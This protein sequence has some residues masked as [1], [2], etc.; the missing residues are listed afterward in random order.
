VL[1]D[2]RSGAW[3]DSVFARGDLGA[4]LADAYAIQISEDFGDLP[5]Q[6]ALRYDGARLFADEAARNARRLAEQARFRTRF[7]TGAT[8]TLPASENVGYSFDPNEVVPFEDGGT[9]Y[10]TTTVR[11]EW[12]TLTVTAGGALVVTDN[13]RVARIVIPAPEDP[14]TRPLR[15]DGWELE[16]AEGWEAVPAGG[17]RLILRKVAHDL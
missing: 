15:G 14:A 5:Q 17:A 9:V 1:L 8:L 13:G 11:D 3:R 12:G 2:E 4:L 6:R 10:L 16:L 7:V